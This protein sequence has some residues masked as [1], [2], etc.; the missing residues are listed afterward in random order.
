MP[1]IG[2]T[3]TTLAWPRLLPVFAF[4]L[5]PSFPFL[6]TAHLPLEATSTE[7][8]VVHLPSVLYDLEPTEL[9][10]APAYG[11]FTIEQEFAIGF[12]GAS[13]N[14]S[15]ALQSTNPTIQVFTE[16]SS[17]EGT[18]NFFAVPFLSSE[19]WSLLKDGLLVASVSRLDEPSTTTN[20]C[21]AASDSAYLRIIN[22][23]A[24]PYA[25]M[26]LN[27]LL[28]CQSPYKWEVN[29]DYKNDC[30]LFI[31]PSD[32]FRRNDVADWYG[33]GG[34]TPGFVQETWGRWGMYVTGGWCGSW[35]NEELFAMYA[36]PS[37]YARASAD[38]YPVYSSTGSHGPIVLEIGLPTEPHY[39]CWQCLP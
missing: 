28:D 38:V 11:N 26:R 17:T 23:P 31:R 8:E 20:Y 18:L 3:R 19:S 6:G 16:T 7:W 37:G 27:S 33:W 35:H 1:W 12:L 10:Y 4:A 13:S 39:L 32:V 14:E 30:T 21:A 25:R 2:S 34:T 29:L 5:L 22:A 24:F 36:P 15:Y 9:L